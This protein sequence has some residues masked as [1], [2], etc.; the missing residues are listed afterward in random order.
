MASPAITTPRT[1]N[2]LRR[3]Q[4]APYLF[5]LPGLILFILFIVWPMLYSLRISFHDWNIVHPEQSIN[6]GFQNYSDTLAD[7]I[8]QRSV[9]N[10][11]LYVIVTVPGHVNHVEDDRRNV[12]VL[13]T[14]TGQ[15]YGLDGSAAVIWSV[16]A[17]SGSEADAAVALAGR[18]GI[19][20]E[21]AAQDVRGFVDTLVAANLLA[22]GGAG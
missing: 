9:L 15:I 21:R 12:V 22:R 8:F 20:P 13:N 11:L 17:A 1:R 18:Y 5:L 16:V 14:E 7:P 6:V 2:P 4:F 10:T 19:P 3:G